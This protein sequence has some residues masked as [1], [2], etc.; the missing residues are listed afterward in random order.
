ME[1]TRKK[2][3]LAGDDFYDT[4]Q[5]CK[6]GHL[7]VRRTLAGVCVECVKHYKALESEAFKQ[8]K[9]NKKEM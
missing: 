7:S 4:G 5:P 3:M 9:I 8:A 1:N 6:N 2:A